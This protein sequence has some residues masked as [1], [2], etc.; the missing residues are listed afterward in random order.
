MTEFVSFS[1]NLALIVCVLLIA[2]CVYR[3]YVG[4]TVADRLQATDIIST[5]LIGIIVLLTLAQNESLLFDV[6]L[7]LAVFSFVGTLVTA[8]FIAEG[9]DY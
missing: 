1:V 4:P 2:P 5:L 6:S 7:V 9:R 8:R 3:L